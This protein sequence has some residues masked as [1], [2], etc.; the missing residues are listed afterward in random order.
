[1]H[2]KRW[3]ASLSPAKRVMAIVGGI[4]V[5][6]TLL[7]Q[8]LHAL[9]MVSSGRGL[10]TYHSAKLVQWN[11]VGLVVALV[12]IAVALIAGLLVRFYLG[13]RERQLERAIRGRPEPR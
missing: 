10:E 3:W 6:L 11:Y 1:M 13:W 2:M 12:A 7:T 9:H 4:G 8:F 5:F